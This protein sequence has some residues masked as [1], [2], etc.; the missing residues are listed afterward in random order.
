MREDRHMRVLCISGSPRVDGNTDYLL[1]ELLATVDGQFIRLADY[2]IVHCTACWKCLETG[3]CVI[4]DDMTEII[5][6]L[7]LESDAIILGSPVFFNNVT[8]DMKA[9]MDRTWCLRGTLRNKIGGAVV[10]GRR[11]GLETAVTAVN[12]FLLKHDMIVANRGVTGLAFEKGEVADDAEAIRSVKN[13]A[14]RIKELKS[15]VV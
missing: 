8:A 2:R 12:G 10:V 11:Y 4:A 1:N 14:Q 9:F 6:P 15:S 3:R 7:L 5:I 13:L